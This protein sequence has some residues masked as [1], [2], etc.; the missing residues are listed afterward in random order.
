MQDYNC[1]RRLE[2]TENDFVV[3]T[4]SESGTCTWHSTNG[5]PAA[6]WSFRAASRSFRYGEMKDTR[7]IIPASA[8]SLATLQQTDGC[9]Q[10]KMNCVLCKHPSVAFISIRKQNGQTGLTQRF[11]EC[12][13]RD[14][15]RK[16]LGRHSVQGAHCRRRVGMQLET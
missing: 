8:K 10:N 13:Q 16:I 15:Q 5:K 6:A 12:S 14:L 4:A 1:C 2:H 11:F 9:T 3:R 7:Q